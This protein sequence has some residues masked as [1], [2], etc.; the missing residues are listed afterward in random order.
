VVLDYST[1]LSFC[2]DAPFLFC[3]DGSGIFSLAIYV[4][5]EVAGPFMPV[6][7]TP[8]PSGRS[9]TPRP[10]P[11]AKDLS[12]SSRKTI[13]HDPNAEDT[14]G[15]ILQI[16]RQTTPADE[17]C[18][19]VISPS[20]PRSPS[21][22][23]HH[24][25]SLVGRKL[26]HYELIESIG[27]G[28]MAAVIKA[29]DADLGRVVALKILPPD[30][31]TDPENVSRFK[32]EAR[33]AAK[34]DHDNVARVYY[35]GEDQ[36]LHYIAFEFVE[37][38]NLRVR[39]EKQGG[40][41]PVADAVPCMIQVTA[42]LAHAASRGVVHRDIKPSNIIITPDGRAKIV[43]MGLARNLDSRSTNGQLTQS[44]VTLGT[45]DYISPEQAIEPR[46]ADCRSDIYSL[47][48]T[49]YHV[50]TGRTPVPEGTA[51]KKLH[52]HEH[53]A[54][55]DPREW[56][57]A[58]PDEM[59]AILGKMMAKNP[60]QRYQQ[61]DHLLQHLLIVADKLNLPTGPVHADANHQ[62]S[63]YVDQPLPAPPSLSP[64]W[65]GLAIVGLVIGLYAI[66]GGFS[67]GRS[68]NDRPFWASEK[69]PRENPGPQGAIYEPRGNGE[70]TEPLSPVK[71]PREA[72]STS[73]LVAFLKHPDAHIKLRPGTTYDLTRVARKD[74]ELPRALFEG[75]NLILECERLLDPPTVR[76]LMSKAEDGAS[77]RPGTL[78]LRGPADG[79][80]A[81]V[82]FRG[83]R[84]EFVSDD[85]EAGQSGIEFHE[86]DLVEIEDCAFIPPARRDEP[87]DGPAALSFVHPSVR[88]LAPS[89]TLDRCWFAPG[90]VAIQLAGD[91][92]QKLRSAECSFG[93]QFAA[94]RLQAGG[95]N[96]DTRKT[97][98]IRLE[99]CSLL[100]TRGAAI[101]IGD[102]VPCQV[103]TGW[104]LFSNPEVPETETTRAFLIRQ[105][106]MAAADTHSEGAR[107]A[108]GA[109]MPNGYNQVLAYA[110]GD[111]ACTFDDCK[112]EQIAVEDS[113]ARILP[114]SPWADERPLKRLADFPRQLK[115]VFAI[116]LKQEILRLDPD[117]NRNLLGIKHLPG[118][119]V[120]DLFPFESPVQ[121][122]RA[123]GNVR[124]WQPDFAEGRPL[125]PNVYR[126]LV[127]ALD[128]LKRGDVLVIR[129]NGPL[130]IDPLEF[131][132]ADTDLT[133]RPDDEFRPILI[134]RAPTL[135]KDPALFKLFGGQLILENL[136]FRL[137]ADRAP[138]IVALPGGG[139]CTFRSCSVTFE[140]GE[141][142]ALVSLA[143]PRGEM[144]MM[145]T[146]T[147]DKWP[148]PRIVVEGSFVRGRG[149]VLQVNASRPF[150]LR[151][152]DTLTVL[153][154]S[155]I[156][157]EASAAD[158]S[159]AS[160]AMVSLDHG[161]T[162][163]TKP[164]L[165]M[166]AAEKR[167]DAKLGLVPVQIHS[168][169]HLFVPATEQGALIMLDRIDNLEQMESV[170]QWKECR[171][172]V[173]GWKSDQVMM[174]IVPDDMDAAVRLERIERDR[175]LGKWRETEYAFG[176][177]NFSVVPGSR[178]FDGVKPGD[179]ELKSI[180]PPLKPEGPGGFGAPIGT[181]RKLLIEE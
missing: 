173:Y 175:W 2:R 92:G 48:C 29:Q 152:K 85:P 97:N 156:H 9:S 88:N 37:G 145:G 122:A 80:P 167:T 39:M 123:V 168:V 14:S 45:F 136:R 51:A 116:D 135:K 15:I 71:G 79:S 76:L 54:P 4:G 12:T 40:L 131:K 140:D 98:E 25:E 119:K 178:R 161:T 47:G 172:N 63:P 26:G 127:K 125:P 120:Y 66:T 102:Q 177:I 34:L 166:R 8:D 74:A 17:N 44:G 169:Q 70:A 91:G 18:P 82:R 99:S 69:S 30:M 33:A 160:P 139:S 27:V 117:K 93:P 153:D 62:I 7:L 109:A 128:D 146:S 155:L 21:P 5:L 86:I 108:D 59:A 60:A 130:E 13:I 118:M 158:W 61:P 179:F 1:D 96:P 101:E 87:E 6:P 114:R 50:L 151:M 16:A 159:E 75:S 165:V 78:T 164:L 68:L 149:R 176:E 134:P 111:I 22:D 55:I 144:M 126:S 83:I 57:P 181:L 10:V 41:L 11:A 38:D 58:I 81:K 19:T 132:K 23:A 95:V 35:C 90:S 3:P 73:E 174:Q 53:V 84:F 157:V 49:F 110:N 65:I 32:L 133:I 107:T 94:F 104:C 100:M 154:G 24:A 52:C 170:F 138:A 64:W 46:S 171:G 137:K 67:D 180:L 148:T 147:P 28:G 36:G 141:D 105:L 129:H 106:G 72:R 142:F 89:I 43:D 31:A 163:L 150:E 121:E 113:G 143:D 124:I 42:G 103:S 162:Y 20:R 77:S 112:Q 56:N 115:P